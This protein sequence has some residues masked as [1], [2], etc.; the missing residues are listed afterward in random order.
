[1]KMKRDLMQCSRAVV[2]IVGVLVMILASWISSLSVSNSTSR[3]IL[4]LNNQKIERG[5][6][7]SIDDRF[8][9]VTIGA[10][11]GAVPKE[12][13]GIYI[14][15]PAAT[16]TEDSIRV[17]NA[18]TQ[19]SVTARSLTQELYGIVGFPDGTTTIIFQELY[20]DYVESYFSLKVDPTLLLG[21]KII[22][23]NILVPSIAD[24]YLRRQR[25]NLETGE[26]LEERHEGSSVIITYDQQFSYNFPED[27]GILTLETL[28]SLPF[29]NAKWSK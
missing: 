26:D 21:S 12:A 15:A 24:R 17:S 2:V 19:H 27:G 6:K 11:P 25:R 18:Y 14:D 29:F 8:D 9:N 4:S 10:M 13:N 7:A 5:L 3:S 22:I 1:M 23:K 16:H 20:D 28:V